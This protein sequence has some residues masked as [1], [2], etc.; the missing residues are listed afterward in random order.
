MPDLNLQLILDKLTTTV[1][2]ITPR[3]IPS[4]PFVPHTGNIPLEQLEENAIRVFEWRDGDMF[5]QDDGQP[6]ADGDS[7]WYGL[8]LSLAIIYPTAFIVPGDDPVKPRGLAGMRLTDVIDLN[9][10]LMFD[11]PLASAGLTADYMLL[12][13][14]RSTR[15]GRVRLLE[16]KVNFQEPF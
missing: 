1:T 10:A 14:I 12:Q 7:T 8:S 15:S 5:T 16:Y 4:I 13:L 9:K 2:G 6:K 3:V 11:D